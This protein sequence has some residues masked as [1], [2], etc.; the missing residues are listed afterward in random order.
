MKKTL[1]LSSILLSSF[2]AQAAQLEISVQNLTQGMVFT[3]SIIAAHDSSAYIFKTGMK[4]SDALQAMAE[5]GDT[6]LLNTML[7]DAGA[8]TVITEGMLAPA[9][10]YSVMLNTDMENMYLSLGAMLL[11][12]NDAFT[13]L[14]SW[15]I[16]TQAGTYTIMI[17]AYDAGTEANTELMLPM[18]GGVPGVVGI[19]G[20]PTM[21]AGTGG[22]GVADMSPNQM[23]HI[24]PGNIGDDM[25]SGGASDLSNTVHRWLNPVAKVTVTVK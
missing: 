17:N 12:T 4:A 10:Q 11:P 20:D 7:M 18:A 15:M 21:A 16:P 14:D 8:N 23:V 25:E 3:P 6:A 22:S 2:A 24:H 5:G 1:L 19:P 13:G 9:G